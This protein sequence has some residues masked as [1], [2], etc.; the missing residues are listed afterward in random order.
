MSKELE[1]LMQLVAIPSITP[2]DGGC[3]KIIT[4]RLQPLGFSAEYINSQT[5]S[6]LWLTHGSGEPVLCFIGHIDVVPTGHLEKWQTPPFTPTIIDGH[7]HGRGSCDMKGG[8]VAMVRA[9][10]DFVAKNPNHSGS[11]TLIITSD[12]EGIA[13]EGTTL[14][15]EKLSA[16]GQKFNYGLV[17]EP[18][19]SEKFGD[20]IKNGRRGSL[21]G[22]LTIIGKQGHVAYAHKGINAVHKF[23]PA[24]LELTQTKWDNGNTDFP[25]TTF[26]ISNI[27]GGTGAKNVIPGEL[28]VEFNFRHGTAS[29]TQSLKERFEAILKK[30]QIEYRL[31]WEDASNPYLTTKADFINIVSECVLAQTGIKPKLETGGGT[32]D[33]RFLAQYCQEVIEFGTLNRTIHQVN[34]KVKIS[35]VEVLKCIYEDVLNKIYK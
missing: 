21:S 2:I 20:T 34:E 6:N 5:V 12:E 24:L 19:C 7:L 22:S 18:T 1:L 14:V 35:D 3:L 31:I 16:R 25:Q 17:A 10:E 32:S 26:Q 4:E 23:A 30:H 27:H 13:T 28:Q 9:C 29:T 8:I 11:I 33:G 15:L